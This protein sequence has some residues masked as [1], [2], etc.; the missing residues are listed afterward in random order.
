MAGPSRRRLSPCGS[1]AK[2]HTSGGA[3]I[4]RLAGRALG[5]VLAGLLAAWAR[6]TDLAEWAIV[7]REL[8]ISDEEDSPAWETLMDAL[9]SA[10]FGEGVPDEALAL[11][12]SLA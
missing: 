2:R 4:K 3:A 1:P 6:G 7:T 8:V 12:R 5:T 9:W 11:A 10:A